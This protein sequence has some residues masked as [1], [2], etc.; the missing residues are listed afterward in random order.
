MQDL[1]AT[2]S[3][4]WQA[5]TPAVL[6]Q[7]GDTRGS[8]PREAGTRMLVSAHEVAGTVGGG[9]LELQAIGVARDM[10]ACGDTV[11]QSVH[12]PLGPALGQCCGGTMTLCFERL[13][14]AHL[15]QWPRV[16]PM[17]H[18][19]LYGAGHVGRAIARLLADL[20]VQVDWLDE[21]QKEFPLSLGAGWP[22]HIRPLAGEGIEDEVKQAP[23]GACYL[24]MTHRHDLDLR[25]TEAVL[26][27]GDFRWFGL[28]GSRTK[29]QRF[30]HRLLERGV[31]SAAIDR[32]VCPVGV[33]GIGGKEPEVI[34]VA[35]V[36]QLLQLTPRS[37]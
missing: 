15:V 35:V 4:W 13:S 33:P 28:I 1:R 36:A 24:V 5:G 14:D 29:K 27:R 31:S 34:A 10:L 26:R 20:P 32:M 16:A 3:R 6:V 37:G 25:I 23:A 2:A 12:Y 8:V 19:Q 9:H 30:V 18:L 17:F 22:P 11:P 21:R 7:V